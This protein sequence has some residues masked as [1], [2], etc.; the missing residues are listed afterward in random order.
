[1][2]LSNNHLF[3]FLIKVGCC[4][5]TLREPVMHEAWYSIEKGTLEGLVSVQKFRSNCHL[6][7]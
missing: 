5:I 4:T 1:M 6:V 2:T 7:N 3:F